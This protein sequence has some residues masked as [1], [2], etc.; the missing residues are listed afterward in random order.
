[1]AYTQ[2]SIH[3]E[4]KIFYKVIDYDSVMLLCCFFDNLKQDDN[5]VVT[6]KV[7]CNGDDSYTSY[8]CKELFETNLSIKSKKIKTVQFSYHNKEKKRD[9]ELDLSHYTGEF[10]LYLPYYHNKTFF[11]NF[12]SISGEDQIWVS[13]QFNQVLSI[14][15]TFKNQNKIIHEHKIKILVMLSII[16]GFYL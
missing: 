3:E 13:G 4:E 1:M 11:R 16:I 6:C 7:Y 14:I 5:D 9:I 8:N 10:Y 15:K 2:Y 12:F